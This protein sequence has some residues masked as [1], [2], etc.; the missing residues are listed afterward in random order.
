MKPTHP[1]HNTSDP[2]WNSLHQRIMQS[3]RGAYYF[4][5]GRKSKIMSFFY[6]AIACASFIAFALLLAFQFNSFETLKLNLGYFTYTDEN[7]LTATL[8]AL[9]ALHKE[10]LI[11]GFT[12]LLA[13]IFS[14]VYSL[15]YKHYSRKTKKN[16]PPFR[17]V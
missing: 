10:L 2:N 8:Q 17:T 7:I 16:L 14:F 13:L 6:F 1:Q 12:A 15:L 5:E 11:L 3:V 9:L 4:F